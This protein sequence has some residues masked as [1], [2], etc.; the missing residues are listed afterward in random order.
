MI[1]N[2]RDVSSMVENVLTMMEKGLEFPSNVRIL[3]G[4][5]FVVLGTYLNKLKG[6]ES[7]SYQVFTQT[8]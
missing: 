3:L 6:R 1:L 2:P 5:K 7:L 8:R 4:T